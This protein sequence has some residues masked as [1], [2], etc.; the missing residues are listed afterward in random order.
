[1]K[2]ACA[3]PNQTFLSPSYVT[4]MMLCLQCVAS[5]GWVAWGG[6]EVG[7]AGWGV[8]AP[9][10][11]QFIHYNGQGRLGEIYSPYLPSPSIYN[12]RF[13]GYAPELFF[14]QKTRMWIKKKNRP[15][16]TVFFIGLSAFELVKL[17]R[18]K[19]R[20]YANNRVES[21]EYVENC[22]PSSTSGYQSIYYRIFRV[23]R[24]LHAEFYFRLPKYIH[25]CNAIRFIY[26][27][28][29]SVQKQIF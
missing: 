20:G 11:T 15:I 1:M 16:S 19:S 2:N 7:Q 5:M 4:S 3:W 12:S 24:K 10:H 29:F 26:L 13:Q 21:L 28:N 23:Y 8:W 25:R 9:H 18:H 22:M 6:G 17:S 27:S 14:N